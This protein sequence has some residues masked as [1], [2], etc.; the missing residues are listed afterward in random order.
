M[1]L[2]PCRWAKPGDAIL[3]LDEI[4]HRDC[5]FKVYGPNDILPSVADF[6]PWGWNFDLRRRLISAG[7]D[8][9]CLPSVEAIKR[10]RELSHR[11]TTI[12]F[13][14]AVQVAGAAPLARRLPVELRSVENVLAWLAV[15][16]GGWLKAPWSSSG[17]G[18]L[19][20]SDLELR[21]IRPWAHGIIRRQGSVMA[22]H[23]VNRALDFASEW[24]CDDGKAEFLGLSVFE[25]SPRGKYLR[26]IRSSQTD[27]EKRV[28]EYAPCWTSQIIAAQREALDILI[29]PFYSGPLGID[30][31]A[32]TEGLIYPC[33][34]INLRRTMGMV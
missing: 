28:K 32:D 29:S 18:V 25:T 1:A 5:G 26:N 2:L 10:L 11:R 30:M 13:N 27:L 33:V 34:E 6:Q 17:R 22:E 24:H 31:M 16:P 20:T 19:R 8:P 23:G 15:N 9:G 14:T 3:V 21:H 7:A 12:P 4:G